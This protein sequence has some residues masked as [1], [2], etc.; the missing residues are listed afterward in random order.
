MG[1]LKCGNYMLHTRRIRYSSIHQTI[2]EYNKAY[3][4]EHDITIC[5]TRRGILLRTSDGRNKV[6][7]LA[8]GPSTQKLGMWVWVI[9]IVVQVL[10]KY[11]I[12]GYL[13]P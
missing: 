12:L 5:P 2:I 13:D 1:T 10:D 3:I 6:L 7:L 9:V 11:M 4:V 8:Q